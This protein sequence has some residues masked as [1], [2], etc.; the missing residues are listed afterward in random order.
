MSAARM[1]LSPDAA[2]LLEY[3]AAIARTRDFL[4]YLEQERDACLD[5]VDRH[6]IDPAGVRPS[7][8]PA[9]FD[10]ML[11]A[12][13]SRPGPLADKLASG[14]RIVSDAED[15]IDAADADPIPPPDDVDQRTPTQADEDAAMNDLHGGHPD[16][17]HY[18]DANGQA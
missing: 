6:H 4:A 18:C 1:K 2:T 5:H 14:M 17:D 13:L 3:S 9:H 7:P 15:V 10:R 11:D 16:D 12:V 8:T